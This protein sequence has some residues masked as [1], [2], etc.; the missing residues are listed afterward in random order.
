MRRPRQ[1]I[2]PSGSRRAL[3]LLLAGTA[4]VLLLPLLAVVALAVLVTSRGPIIFTQE[5]IGQGGVPF[6][7]YKFRSMRCGASGP[8]VTTADDNRLTPIGK[9]LRLLGVDELPQLLNVLRGDMTLVGPRPESAAL[10]ARYPA[11]CAAVFQ[12]RPALTGPAAV[13][14]RDRDEL[15]STFEDLEAYYL[16]VVV[17][18]KVAVDMQF[19]A[20]P[21]LPQTLGVIA[22]TAVYLITGGRTRRTVPLR[23][24]LEQDVAEAP[25]LPS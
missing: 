9:L 5:R 23:V 12:Y 19:L 25:S 15:R 21:T 3:D 17:P 1:G 10:A 6:T 2:A 11:G 16:Q 14:L 4:F 8:D 22:E 24:E 7:L 18:T 13:R 20:A